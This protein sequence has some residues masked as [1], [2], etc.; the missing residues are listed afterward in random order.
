MANDPSFRLAPRE[1]TLYDGGQWRLQG[2]T[3]PSFWRQSAVTVRVGDRTESGLH[4]LQL[5]TR[6]RA[7]NEEVLVFY[8]ADGY[9]RARPLA[10]KKLP[11]KADPK[12]PTAYGSSFLIGPIDASD[13]P[14][15]DISTVTFDPY[16]SSFDLEFA[17][18]GKAEL[19]VKGLDSVRITLNVALSS[20]ITSGP[21][22][23]LRSMYVSA[24]NAD[25]AKLKWQLSDGRYE[26]AGIQQ[27]NRAP[28]RELWAGR[29]I[30]SHH[31]TSAPDMI[32]REFHD[33][34]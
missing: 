27:F 24:D 10:P 2:I 15:V 8:P 3:Y 33:A 16:R 4:L 28:V 5:W 26:S 31:N 30:P 18:G 17:R 32:F 29:E 12:L 23:A 21:F 6:T 14:F 34:K 25:A 7:R 19:R 22:A 13:R 9:W 11:W 20:P 1:V